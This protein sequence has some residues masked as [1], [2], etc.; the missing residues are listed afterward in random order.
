[1]PVIC[2]WNIFQNLGTMHNGEST[3]PLLNN[4]GGAAFTKP[5][6]NNARQI[7]AGDEG[8]VGRLTGAAAAEEGLPILSL[9]PLTGAA[10]TIQDFPR[11]PYGR[12]G[13]ALKLFVTV[14]THTYPFPWLNVTR[15]REVSQTNLPVSAFPWKTAWDQAAGNRPVRLA[16]DQRWATGWQATLAWPVCR[17]VEKRITAGEPLLCQGEMGRLAGKPIPHRPVREAGQK[18]GLATLRFRGRRTRP[19]A[20]SQ[21][22]VWRW[23]GQLMRRE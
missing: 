6:Q 3:D 2:Y 13:A 22:V 14:G 17:L 5:Q 16:G 12:W 20:A 19:L 18:A 7:S 1:M 4:P 11:Q 9:R 21:S 15:L 8:F 10:V 23:I